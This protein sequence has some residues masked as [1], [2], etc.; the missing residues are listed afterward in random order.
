[1]WRSNAG[2][3]VEDSRF[4][5]L[6]SVVMIVWACLFVKF[7]QRQE[8]HFSVAWGSIWASAR[9]HIRPEF[10]GAVDVP[11]CMSFVACISR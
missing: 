4:A 6:F 5:P 1:M 7:W 9:I 8:A 11:A 10:K 3:T 2:E